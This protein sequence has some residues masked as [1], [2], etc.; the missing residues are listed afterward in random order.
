MQM[1]FAALQSQYSEQSRL[2][3]TEQTGVR[4]IFF[5]Q[6]LQLA[7]HNPNRSVVESGKNTAT[8]V[9][10]FFSCSLDVNANGTYFSS[11]KIFVA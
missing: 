1:S 6:S 10:I 9:T 3:S 8:V 11:I 7:L 2:K 5:A 4:E